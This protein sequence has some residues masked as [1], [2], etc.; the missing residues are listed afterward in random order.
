MTDN[1]TLLPA[2]TEPEEEGRRLAQDDSTSAVPDAGGSDRDRRRRVSM[3]DVSYDRGAR[4]WVSEKV[5]L[6]LAEQYLN[7]SVEQDGAEPSVR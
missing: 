7:Y 5:Q 3:E 4:Q 1:R 6:D 2:S